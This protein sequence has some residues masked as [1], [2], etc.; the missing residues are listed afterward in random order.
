[1][2]IITAN[3]GCD[4]DLKFPCNLARKQT[5]VCI[6]LEGGWRTV[7]V[8]RNVTLLMV[9]EP[10]KIFS[11]QWHAEDWKARVR[12]PAKTTE[13]LFFAPSLLSKESRVILGVM[14]AKRGANHS[15]PPSD[16]DKNEW[17]SPLLLLLA[18]MACYSKDFT[19][20][21]TELRLITSHI[22]DLKDKLKDL[23]PVYLLSRLVKCLELCALD[24]CLPWK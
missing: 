8:K 23:K 22:A 12:I 2:E 19:S 14:R 7:E 3:V 17:S 20:L 11:M 15:H 4:T 10:R 24:L 21:L 16:E 6:E 18:F 1:M 5:L 13:F 9:K